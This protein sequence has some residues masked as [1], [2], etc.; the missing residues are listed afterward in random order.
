[1][2]FWIRTVA[3]LVAAV[4]F[5]LNCK[6]VPCLCAKSAILMDAD[7]GQVLCAQGETEPALIA[8]T[9]KIMTA[10]LVV[11]R[12]DL[13]RRVQIPSEA[14]GIEGS[15]IYLKAGEILTVREL[16][17]GMM[18]HSGNDA[19]TAL[20]LDHSGSI[21]AFAA[22][23][24]RKAAALGLENSHFANP[25]GL[26]SEENYASAQDL[27]HLTQAALREPEFVEI[28]STKSI[29]IGDRALTNHNKLLWTVEGA[30]GVKTGYTRAAGRILVSAAERGGRRLIAV[31]INDGNDWRDHKALY[32]FGFAQYTEAVAIQV[33]ETVTAVPLLDG[34]SAPLLA[35]EA[36]S[37]S[38]MEGEQL[39][40]RPLWPRAA[41]APGDAGTLAGYGG[42]FVGERCVGT[43]SLRWGGAEVENER[44]DTENL[45]CPGSCL[46][47]GG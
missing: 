39:T 30:M 42:V 33:G 9:T 2:K 46:P 20:A 47:A 38:L 8:S 27:A 43:I 26:D 17:Y 13:D 5:T 10:L 7:T 31:T 21:E 16:L 11:E 23:M 28:V 6:A 32:D 15:S 29:R 35:G 34:G 19:A 18:L 3:S 4:L 25:H 44:T 24:N 12:G 40:V 36:F 1:M 41:F 45:V 14:T 22:E 37:F